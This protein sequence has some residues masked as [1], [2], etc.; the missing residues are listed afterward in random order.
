MSIT[1]RGLVGGAATAAVLVPLRVRAQSEDAR[2]RAL[3]DQVRQDYG[4]PG[5]T[6]ALAAGGKVIFEAQSGVADTATR[7]P[8]TGQSL[9]RIASCTKPFTSA[10]MML[11]AST[12]RP[13]RADL[14]QKV[15]GAGG[16]LAELDVPG[17]RNGWEAITVRQL[18]THTAGCPTN[19]GRD[20]MFAPALR[21]LGDAPFIREVATSRCL[22]QEMPRDGAC[23]RTSPGLQYA[24]SN[25]GFYLL[26][27]IIGRAAL[28]CDA[29]Q[30][31]APACEVAG[32]YGRFV[33]E[34]VLKPRGIHGMRL[35]RNGVRLPNEVVY[36]GENG[37]NPYGFNIT[38]MAAHGGWVAT[39]HDVAL[40]AATALQGLP[41]A[42]EQRM[43][44]P[45]P[46]SLAAGQPYGEGW[47]LGGNPP[48][49]L[50]HN[51]SLPGTTSILWRQPNG[52]S[53]AA[54]TNLRTGRTVGGRSLLTA[55][56]QLGYQLFTV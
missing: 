29:P 47:Q 21:N 9:F 2:R 34:M 27:A 10:A 6:V 17:M 14:D 19:D 1:R 55:I 46:Q 20:P 37:E 48:Y 43:A 4:L 23:P 26:G 5:L 33:Q 35:A 22:N 24:Y 45:T 7:E 8:V 30:P 18:L 42:M 49:N 54:M 16:L 56:D 40:F 39:A 31:D 13:D 52:R 3:V 32:P 50:W 51:G 15:F 53:Y 38:R 25:F 12:G 41:E 36:Y 44:T 28:R 11:A